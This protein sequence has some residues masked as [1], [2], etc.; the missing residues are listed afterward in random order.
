MKLTPSY[1]GYI[2]KRFRPENTKT[3]NLSQNTME[4]P[5]YWR[6][7][8]VFWPANNHNREYQGPP[9]QVNWI[10]SNFPLKLLLSMGLKLK[11][12]RGPH[13]NKKRARGPQM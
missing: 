10:S 13:F 5:C 9:V 3:V 8:P 7:S 2:Y 12:T 6:F 11:Y 4:F 1:G